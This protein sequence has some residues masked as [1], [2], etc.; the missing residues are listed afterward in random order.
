MSMHED[1]VNPEELS[2]SIVDEQGLSGRMRDHLKHCPACQRERRHLM[3]Q[4][5]LIGRSAR[6]YAP[7]PL[8]KIVLP[9]SEE[10]THKGWTFGWSFSLKI[11]AVAALAVLT[12]SWLVNFPYAPEVDQTSIAREMAGD[13]KLLAEVSML[14]ENS[15]PKAYE[16]IS[17][18]TAADLDEDIFDFVVPISR[19]DDKQQGQ[20]IKEV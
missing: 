19:I 5:D 13:E 11:A 16:E 2:R 9:V 12:V 1:H 14:E 8:R 17:P 10:D 6:R 18:E 7:E 15:L 4:L 3:E 20:T